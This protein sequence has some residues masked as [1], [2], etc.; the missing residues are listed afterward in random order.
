MQEAKVQLEGN[1]PLPC[2]LN[3]LNLKGVKL[4]CQS[5][6]AIVP[7]TTISLRLAEDYTVKPVVCVVWHEKVQGLYVYGIHFV[8]I[9][10]GDKERI[11]RFFSYILSAIV[12]LSFFSWFFPFSSPR[13][14]GG[15]C[16]SQ[17]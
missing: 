7:E 3:D 10:D 12:A 8:R 15:T 4:T 11:Y 9:N 2:V 17:Q 13:T 6:L 1:D 16:S 14:W 5:E